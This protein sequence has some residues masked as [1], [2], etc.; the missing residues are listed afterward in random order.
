MK[1]REIK[2]KDLKPK[3]FID[4]KVRE[5]REIAGDGIAISALSGGVDSSVVTALAHKALGRKLKTYF[6]DNGIMREGEPRRVKALFKELG[7]PVTIV[8]ARQAF[9]DA[10]KG[11]TDPELKREAITQT[12]YRKV[13]RDLVLKS[14]ATVLLQGTILTDIEETAAGIKRQH[15]VFEQ[16]GID[17]K[18][19]MTIFG[20]HGNIGPASVPIVLS[21]LRELGR[22]KKGD[23]VALLGIGSGLNCSMAEVV[24]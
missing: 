12:F 19:V 22:L 8:D 17:P 21:K 15:N 14:R 23:R 9:F 18:K 6:I 7:I 4:E 1:Y 2:A 3:T 20:E 11:I 13:F 10:M 16:I 24:W 5:I